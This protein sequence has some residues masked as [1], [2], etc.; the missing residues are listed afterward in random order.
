MLSQVLQKDLAEDQPAHL[1][2]IGALFDKPQFSDVRVVAADGEGFYCHRA[3][4]AA[5][6]KPFER[7]MLTEGVHAGHVNKARQPG[8]TLASAGHYHMIVNLVV[9]ARRN[10]ACS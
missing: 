5:C 9:C 6:S 1:A 4:L 10:A 3:I 2:R 8:G 7:A